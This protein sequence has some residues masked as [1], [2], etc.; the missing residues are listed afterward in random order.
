MRQPEGG[1]YS[2]ELSKLAQQLERNKNL[3]QN[4]R[5]AQEKAYQD[6]NA[7]L[8]SNCAKKITQVIGSIKILE[9]RRQAML[10]DEEARIREAKEIERRRR[11]SAEKRRIEGMISR[12]N[13]VKAKSEKLWWNEVHL[14]LSLLREALQPAVSGQD[15]T[16]SGKLQS[17]LGGLS[18][19]SAPRQRLSPVD[20]ALACQKNIVG[21]TD[22]FEQHIIELDG[23]NTAD[24]GE[25]S[26]RLSP[27][28]SELKR[29]R[30]VQIKRIQGY[31]SRVEEAG[32]HLK[33]FL[34]MQKFL[35]QFDAKSET[36]DNPSVASGR[37]ARP[38]SARP[39]SARPASRTNPRFGGGNDAK[40]S[41]APSSQ[42]RY[43]AGRS[44]TGGYTRH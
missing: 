15:S 41:V 19:A 9:Q 3:L 23:I 38:A 16:I 12:L 33:G 36:L 43:D 11:E 28:F 2:D 31:I 21:W 10:D 18:G 34:E 37:A 30:K 17:F 40:S 4:L 42:R 5:Q 32:R 22:M 27:L 44:Y 39:A 26:E 14:S 13:G 35:T 29:A 6:G 24:F 7:M 8:A 25:V 20:R 1:S